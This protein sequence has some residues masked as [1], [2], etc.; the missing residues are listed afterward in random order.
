M[1]KDKCAL[2]TLNVLDPLPVYKLDLDKS[3]KIVLTENLN[4]VHKY[5]E[6]SSNRSKKSKVYVDGLVKHERRT[7]YP[8]HILGN[9][10]CLYLSLSG[11]P[12]VKPGYE[13]IPSTITIDFK[14]FT[15]FQ[16]EKL[17]EKGY[18]SLTL[19]DIL[20]LIVAK[21][22]E[23]KFVFPLNPVDDIDKGRGESPIAFAF[24]R[25]V[26]D[27]LQCDNGKSYIKDPLNCIS[28]VGIPEGYEDLNYIDFL[29]YID[30]S[31]S[32][33]LEIKTPK[34]YGIQSLGGKPVPFKVLR[35]DSPEKS[36]P[37]KNMASSYSKRKQCILGQFSSFRINSSGYTERSN[38]ALATCDIDEGDG[39]PGGIEG[40]IKDIRE[41]L[42][43]NLYI[44]SSGKPKV[45]VPI[46]HNFL[47]EPFNGESFLV[48]D[49]RRFKIH[50]EHKGDRLIK[51]Y[52]SIFH[53]REHNRMVRITKTL[54]I[55][56]QM[57]MVDFMKEHGLEKVLKNVDWCSN[58]A[59]KLFFD[60]HGAIQI[61]KILNNSKQYRYDP[62]VKRSYEVVDE[63]QNT[64]DY[65]KKYI[66]DGDISS[67]STLKECG[68]LS[69]R[70]NTKLGHPSSEDKVY[71]EELRRTNVSL[72]PEAEGKHDEI[73]RY[74]VSTLPLDS[75]DKEL[76]GIKGRC[77]NEE[78]ILRSLIAIGRL[79]EG[80]DLPLLV[81]ANTIRWILVH[82]K[83]K[84]EIGQ[85]INIPTKRHL[86]NV[87]DDY[88]KYLISI[89]Q[90]ERKSPKRKAGRAY[91]YVA[92]GRLLKLIEEHAKKRQAYLDEFLM[93]QGDSIG[94]IRDYETAK[95]AL[96]NNHDLK[97][98]N[99]YNGMLK[100]KMYSAMQFIPP[101]EFFHHICNRTDFLEVSK[102][103]ER[104]N[105]LEKHF[106]YFAENVSAS[107]GKAK[108]EEIVANYTWA[109]RHCSVSKGNPY[110]L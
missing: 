32:S 11:K 5:Y 49:V 65:I 2:L 28:K 60:R 108:L 96:E 45:L 72:S 3:S 47:L 61:Q 43:N 74:W 76:F 57:F 81:I 100:H 26:I 85:N 12:I 40:I 50:K 1:I 31:E 41:K 89:D 9:F 71:K 64:S 39:Y 110:S 54:I 51:R 66:V 95:R 56:S 48:E 82:L 10:D 103:S 106:S 69:V 67:T 70:V 92:K 35:Y 87:S 6:E 104:C 46:Y 77:S 16:Q 59:T 23:Y 52:L 36:C 62:F 78:F 105:M 79:K 98:G 14:Q 99:W 102:V 15:S 8:E 33:S 91:T 73:T 68:E 80:F 84:G 37:E 90:L 13:G 34:D 101:E 53:R 19:Q 58:A 4:L 27:N 109:F 97:S 55:A 29:D 83:K 21:E 86:A 7:S 75:E 18:T 63:I 107:I 24:A 30:V 25:N 17:K 42:P 44:S 38:Y 94:T 93:T 20:D 22:V 88:L